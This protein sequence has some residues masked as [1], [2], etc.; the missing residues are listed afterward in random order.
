MIDGDGN[1]PL[2]HSSVYERH[3]IPPIATGPYRPTR[4]LAPGE[5]GTVS[6]SARDPWNWTGLY[7]EAGN[8]TFTATGRWSDLRIVSG[9]A[10]PSG[11]QRFRPGAGLHLAGTLIGRAERL[12]R[13]VTRNPMAYFLLTRR[14][15]N[16]PWMSL[17]GVV[18]NDAI[19]LGGTEARHE[20]IPIGAGTNHRVGR[21]GY[22]YAFAN[23]A[24]G[25]YGKNRGSV[26]LE[27]TRIS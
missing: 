15:E 12:F 25:C 21:P 5:S 24:W 9:P 22:L 1:N 19:L 11:R 8:Y 7:L 4:T 14:D 10:G 16:M 20:Q 23:N 18:A 6:V 26:Q 27:V 17:I 2:L 13:R 3:Q